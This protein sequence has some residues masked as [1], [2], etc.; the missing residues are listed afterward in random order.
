L[1]SLLTTYNFSHTVNFATG[2]QNDSNTAISNIFVDITMLSSSSA[3]PIIS[4][5]SDYDAQLL[6]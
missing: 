6:T 1:N 2:T 5:L 4:G 3:C